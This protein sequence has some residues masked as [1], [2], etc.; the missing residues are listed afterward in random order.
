MRATMSRLILYVYDVT[1]LTS[2]YRTHFGLELC[3]EIE[4]EWAVMKAGAM[5]LALHR[6]G[7]PYR[8]RQPQR[9]SMTNAKMVFS[10]ESGL[11]ELRE[12]LSVAGVSMRELKRY[13]GF[14]Q[15]M[16]DGE[17]PE[18]NVFQLSQRD[19]P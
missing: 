14:P 18:G 15:L 13:Q 2:F 8:E 9:R 1:A 16:C 12:K 5:E 11:V 10:I 6:V 17:D 3:E 19:R 4:G 7:E